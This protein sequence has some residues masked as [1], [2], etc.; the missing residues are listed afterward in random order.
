VQ[1]RALAERLITYDTSTTEG[2]QTAA[3]FI[4]GW[5]EAR[6]IDVKDGMHNGVPVL[7]ATIGP[8]QG[9]TLIFHGHVDV[10]PGRPEQFVPRVEGDRLIGRGAYDMKGGLAA[11]MC[12]LRDVAEQD[13]VRVHFV[14]VADEESDTPTQRGS[15]YLVENGYTGDFA[16]T[17]EPTDLMIGVQAKGV[18]AL[19]IEVRGKAAHGSTP[20]EGDNAVLKAVE[21]FRAIESLPFADESSELF[22]KPS[23]SLGRIM[24]GDA[25]NKVPDRCV[26]DVDIRYLPGQDPKALLAQIR[27]IAATDVSI[28]FHR[29]PAIVS[30]RDPH[31]RMLADA[32]EEGSSVD[33]I[34]IGRDGASDAI[35]FLEAGVPAVEFGP[36]GAGHHGPDEWVSVSSLDRY[37]KALVEFVDRVGDSLEAAPHGRLEV[38]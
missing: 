1:E 14:V 36:S 4:K 26:I 11:M 25:L 19:R 28:I 8:K 6:E 5:L 38:A 29:S 12:A 17:G 27:S 33:R 2:I 18:L 13:R 31:V 30:R 34:S 10:V 24:G 32:V 23:M 37:R 35:S 7:A 21:V 22:P 9:P 15:D 3:G 20:W 16:I